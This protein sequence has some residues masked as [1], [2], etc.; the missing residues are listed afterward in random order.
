MTEI[1]SADCT[2]PF[3]VDIFFN[4]IDDVTAAARDDGIIPARHGLGG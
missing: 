3:T 1:I 4:N 2:A